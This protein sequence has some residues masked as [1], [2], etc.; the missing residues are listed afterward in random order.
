MYSRNTRVWFEAM[1]EE[2]LPEIGLLVLDVDEA[3]LVGV[4]DKAAMNCAIER[5][6]QA[7]SLV[8]AALRACRFL[9]ENV[10][11][12]ELCLCEYAAALVARRTQLVLRTEDARSGVWSLGGDAPA[13]S[14]SSSSADMVVGMAAKHAIIVRKTLA[15]SVGAEMRTPSVRM[16]ARARVSRRELLK[17]LPSQD[18]LLGALPTAV[19][20][21]YVDETRVLRGLRTRWRRVIYRVVLQE[22][23][24]ASVE[25]GHLLVN[26]SWRTRAVDGLVTVVVVAYLVAA[27][28]F[29]VGVHS[30]Q[31]DQSDVDANV[32]VRLLPPLPHANVRHMRPSS[33]L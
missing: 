3:A 18:C 28:L 27:T 22:F 6:Q 15:L 13:R 10:E 4:H 11:Q 31:Q 30:H 21:A 16:P 1:W 14:S 5:V 7:L 2:N 29:I 32:V 19:S 8:E 25:L 17:H 12:I 24:L 20:A 9:G 26:S 23:P 33:P